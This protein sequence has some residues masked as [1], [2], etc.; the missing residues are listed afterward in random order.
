VAPLVAVVTAIGPLLAAAVMSSRVQA[1]IRAAASPPKGEAE[2]GTL[3]PLPKLSR[4]RKSPLQW[5]DM[6]EEDLLSAT[7]TRNMQRPACSA[8]PDP[9]SRVRRGHGPQNL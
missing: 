4:V 9:N 7:E 6:I 1:S 3:P 5:A 8:P 2:G